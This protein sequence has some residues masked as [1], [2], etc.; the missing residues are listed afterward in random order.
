MV[1]GLC[2]LCIT[3]LHFENGIFSDQFNFWI[4]SFMV[5]SFY[6]I[7]GWLTAMKKRDIPT[8]DLFHLRLKQ[9]GQPY[10][11]FS[12]LI[13]LFSILWAT[14]GWMSWQTIARDIYKMITLRGI[15]TLW[16]LPALFFGE[17]IF[18]WLR[19]CNLWWLYLLLF[20]CSQGYGYAYDIWSERYDKFS[21]TQQLI[22][23]LLVVILSVIRAWWI[24]ALGYITYRSLDSHIKHWGTTKKLSIGCLLVF[25]SLVM[26]YYP[27]NKDIFFNVIFYVVVSLGWLLLFD[28]AQFFRPLH[29]FS[30]WGKNSLILMC[31]HYSIVMVALSTLDYKVFGNMDFTGARTLVYFGVAILLEYPI[32]WLIRRYAPFA[33]GK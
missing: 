16:F 5:P 6:F 28:G 10:F 20:L 3:L 12:I 14:C 9:L 31:T 7:S 19:K 13:L 17:V 8:K 2:I 15:G 22:D 1:K 11:W 26:A 33:L 30:Y 23:S 21:L 25:A 4:G 29:F 27:I 32:V 24:I 18:N